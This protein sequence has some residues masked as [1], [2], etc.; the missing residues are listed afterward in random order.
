MGEFEN[1]AAM[2]RWLTHTFD[3]LS[4]DA[5]W[6]R[7]LGGSLEPDEMSEAAEYGARLRNGWLHL[8]STEALNQVEVYL[9]RR[10]G[11]AAR[12]AMRYGLDGAPTEPNRLVRKVHRIIADLKRMSEGEAAE[13]QRQVDSLRAAARATGDL[14]D[15]AR[16]SLLFLASMVALL[17]GL[18]DYAA[19]MWAWF[20]AT[21]CGQVVLGLSDGGEGGG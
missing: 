3:V 14:S 19:A 1:N 21:R 12:Q 15:R 10:V 20:L 18:P 5:L 6:T 8:T 16:C 11:R 2:Q 9:V 7:R 17:I 13:L 4:R